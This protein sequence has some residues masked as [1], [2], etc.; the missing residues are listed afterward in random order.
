[1]KLKDRHQRYDTFGSWATIVAAIVLLLVAAP[2]YSKAN[3]QCVNGRCRQV[4]RQ[5]VVTQQVIAQP[6][7]YFVGAP[8]RVEAVQ[9]HA[10]QSSPDW[11]EYVEALGFKRG[12]E[13]A[14][15]TGAEKLEQPKPSIAPVFLNRCASCHS[16]EDAKAGV[17]LDGSVD[18]RNF[19]PTKQLAILRATYGETMPP[20]DPLDESELSQLF[21]FM[22]SPETPKG[23][24]PR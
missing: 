13:A 22:L 7:Q 1:M 4:A 21:A 12:F 14:Q 20:Q 23:G 8:A 11:R 17:F 6:V 3:G 18:P 24:D 19:D 5:R 9:Q 15:S 2:S 16:G 10:L